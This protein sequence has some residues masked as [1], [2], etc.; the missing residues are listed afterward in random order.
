M[1]N[2]E[3]DEAQRK[4]EEAK[5]QEEEEAREKAEVA[6]RKEEA[7]TWGAMGV[8]RGCHTRLATECPILSSL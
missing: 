1:R 7:T 4:A 8:S 5:G 2:V 6:R 3:E